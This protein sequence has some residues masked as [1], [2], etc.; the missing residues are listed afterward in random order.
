MVCGILVPGPGMEPMSP[1][2]AAWSLNCQTTKEVLG[3]V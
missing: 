1:A 3:Y 2:L